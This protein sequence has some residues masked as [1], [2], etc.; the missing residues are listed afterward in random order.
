MREVRFYHLTRQPLEAALPRLLA[1]ALEAGHKIIV[2][3]PS[4]VRMQA[5]DALLWAY[6][7][8]SFL[9]HGTQAHDYPELQPIYL[10]LGTENPN[11]ATLLC[12]VD[13]LNPQAGDEA[14]ALTLLL[15]EAQVETQLVQARQVWR[16][17]QDQALQRTYWQQSEH[18][19]WEKK[20]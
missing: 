8:D 11:N 15:F 17:L 16:S 1:K 12:L 7:P 20:Q 3:T 14:Y 6:D 2:R 19:G 13:D 5:L 10:T 9:P 18:G 4:L